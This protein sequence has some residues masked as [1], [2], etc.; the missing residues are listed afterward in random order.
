MIELLR[1]QYTPDMSNDDKIN[2]VREFLQTAVLKILYDKGYFK[3]LAF[4]GGTAL[5]VLFDLRRFSEDLDFSLTDNGG[6]D[7][8]RVNSEIERELKLYGLNVETK[9]KEV[10]TVQSAFLK[11]PGLLKNLGL[12]QLDEEK[13]SI[14]IEVDSNPPKGWKLAATIINKYYL[15][16]IV[17]FDLPSLYATK[18]HACFFRKY[19]KGRDFYD[20]VWYI[21]RKIEPNFI[22]LNNAVEQTEGK[23]PHLDKD[24]FRQFMLDKLSKIDFKAARKDVERFLEDKNELKIL[25]AE[26]ISKAI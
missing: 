3:N 20:L 6:Y 10:R 13:L 18:L 19:V 4:V 16:N 21:G 17:H 22:L 11:F 15:F 26:I 23:S 14:K 2:R 25:D 1:Q 12:S 7:F 8:S 5:R 24:N 9:V